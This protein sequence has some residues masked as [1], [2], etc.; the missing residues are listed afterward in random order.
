MKFNTTPIDPSINLDD[1]RK[2]PIMLFTIYIIAAGYYWI[3]T[4]IKTNSDTSYFVIERL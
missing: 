3:R 2:S 1:R 4:G